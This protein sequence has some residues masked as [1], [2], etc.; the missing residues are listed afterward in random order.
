M[1]ISS[2]DA[3]KS[4]SF[5]PL[6]AVPLLLPLIT[7]FIYAP[8]LPYAEINGSLLFL[9][10]ILAVLS[11][12]FW[13]RDQKYLANLLNI[14][15]SGVLVVGL[16]VPALVI[17]YHFTGRWHHWLVSICVGIYLITSALVIY[18]DE[19][20]LIIR[21]MGWWDR[22][23]PYQWKVVKQRKSIGS[24]GITMT[25]VKMKVTKK[26]RTRAE[27]IRRLRIYITCYGVAT[28][29]SFVLTYA[30][31]SQFFQDL[32]GAVDAYLINMWTTVLA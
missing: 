24:T 14:I 23:F 1:R 30:A 21:L 29:I 31:L 22:K 27:L 25:R 18:A 6:V 9:S 15:I 17:T 19:M 12:S 26:L 3:L 13:H 4:M 28:L 16:L 8:G 7:R 10:W 11:A 32:F 20:D 2:C 5:I